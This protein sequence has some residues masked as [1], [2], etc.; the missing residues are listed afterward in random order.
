MTFLIGS[1]RQVLSQFIGLWGNKGNNF[2]FDAA[3]DALE[4]HG[5]SES[6]SLTLD[7]TTSCLTPTELLAKVGLLSTEWTKYWNTKFGFQADGCPIAYPLP[8]D[9]VDDGFVFYTC[10][11]CNSTVTMSQN[12]T[13]D[14]TPGIKDVC[15]DYRPLKNAGLLMLPALSLSLIPTLMTGPIQERI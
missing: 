1:H 3:F 9:Q 5:Y 13:D 7:D 6:S 10:E 12:K 4:L 14:A 2:S 8:A 15:F 11:G